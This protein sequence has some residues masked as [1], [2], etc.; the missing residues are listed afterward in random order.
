MNIRNSIKMNSILQIPK[1]SHLKGEDGSKIVSIRITAEILKRL[2]KAAAQ[3][4]RS[5]NQIINMLLEYALENYFL[6]RLSKNLL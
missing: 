5:R 4:N 1:K 2:E 3:T 6:S